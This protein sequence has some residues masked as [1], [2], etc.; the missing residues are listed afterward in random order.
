M[1]DLELLGAQPI[2]ALQ[3]QL[4]PSLVALLLTG[5]RA[6]GAQDGGDVD[7]VALT[8]NPVMQRQRHFDGTTVYDVFVDHPPRVRHELERGDASITVSM[9][10]GAR[11]IVDRNGEAQ[12]LIDLA[13]GV[14]ARGRAEAWDGAVFRATAEVLDASRA[15]E[16]CGG[17]ELHFSL[18]VAHFVLLAY[19]AFAALSRTWTVGT[20]G[21]MGQLARIRPDL[22]DLFA[23]ALDPGAAA[24][25]RREAVT[26]A[27]G[28][29]LRR[30]PGDP[31]RIAGPFIDLRGPA[32]GR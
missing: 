30:R 3:A 19:N 22:H 24:G 16:R 23:T 26:A 5:S 12:R 32:G 9:F 7:V 21:M 18:L 15:V 8:A 28:L 31:Y 13:R 11:A 17:D 25:A 6:H 29:V 27:A 2:V 20:P 4:G 1:T 10:A 14:H